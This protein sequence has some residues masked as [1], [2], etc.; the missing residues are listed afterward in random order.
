MEIKIIKTKKKKPLRICGH[1][2]DG[3][4]KSYFGRDSLFIDVEGGIDNFPK[5]SIDCVNQSTEFFMD[6]LRYIAKNHKD[7]KQNTITIDSIDW[8][9]RMVHKQICEERGVSSGSINDKKLAFGVGHQI[10]ASKFRE[11]LN[12][13]DHIRDLGFNIYLI[14]HSKV[15]SVEDPN[16]DP[17]D[18]WDLALQK[19]VRNYVREWCDIVAFISMETF[20]KKQESDFGATKFKPTSTGRRLLYIGNDP[21]YESKTRIPLPDKIDLDWG[22]F[23][24]AIADARAEGNSAKTKTKPKTEQKDGT[25]GIRL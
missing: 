8:V 3:Q 16:L 15:V 23:M 18:R 14:S 22:V 2:R 12:A 4:G 21:S 19:N 5:E 24:S 11:I 1:G 10:A 13:L 17:Y 20:T 9:E 7:I 25:N 6:A